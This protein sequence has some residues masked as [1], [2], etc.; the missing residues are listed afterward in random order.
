MT[1]AKIIDNAAWAA[2]TPRLSVLIPFHGDDPA[3]LVAALDRDGGEVE[4]LVLDDG[5][6]D[7][8]L[9]WSVER[10]VMAMQAPARF[11]RLTA[12]EGRARGRNRL[13]ANARGGHLLCLDADM[14]PDADVFLAAWL[15]LVRRDNPAV[16]FGGFSMRHAA[17]DAAHAL[18]RAMALRT[19][20]LPAARRRLAPEKYVFTSNLLIRRDVFDAERFDESFSGW[21]WE[22]VEWAMRVSRRWP[23]VHIDN[24]ATHLGLDSAPAI[25]RKYEQSAA[26]FA[27]VVAAHLDIVSAYPSYKAARFL[28]RAPLRRLWR[29]LLKAAALADSAPIN[30]RAFSMRLYRAAL[31]AEAV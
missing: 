17:P 15:D 31:Y 18:H 23:I 21:G 25:A 26:N 19:D 24:S 1:R 20:C 2:A 27:R 13:A 14:L 8:E 16:A 6:G 5:S 7:A 12:N 29:P 10:A 22:D 30:L 9:A 11:I 28:K 3:R 4:L